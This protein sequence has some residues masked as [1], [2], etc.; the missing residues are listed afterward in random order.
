MDW[1]GYYNLKKLHTNCSRR[2]KRKSSKSKK[3]FGGGMKR[4]KRNKIPNK[5]G[6]CVCVERER[7][8]CHEPRA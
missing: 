2:V 8:R 1:D 7:E 4:Y 6:V 5:M 3:I